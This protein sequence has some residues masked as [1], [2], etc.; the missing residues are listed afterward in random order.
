MVL[1]LV[2]NHTEDDWEYQN[3]MEAIDQND[4]DI[5]ARSETSVD[6]DDL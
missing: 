1:T 5:V 2:V 4:A 6:T 3:L